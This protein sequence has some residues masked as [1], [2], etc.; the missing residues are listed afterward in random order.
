MQRSTVS[1]DVTDVVHREVEDTA[2]LLGTVLQTKVKL[3]EAATKEEEE[4]AIPVGLDSGTI[5]MDEVEPEG[6]REGGR[7]GG[8]LMPSPC[9]HAAPWQPMPAL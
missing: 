1:S 8:Q 2:S 3:K 7:E 4:G 5:G 6:G 9:L